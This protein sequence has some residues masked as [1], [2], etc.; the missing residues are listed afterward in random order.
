MIESKATRNSNIEFLRLVAMFFIVAGHYL[1]YSGLIETVT[2][3]NQVFA[4]LIGS[5]ARIA[6]SLFLMIGIWYMIDREF[7]AR[8]L[9]K[10]YFEIWFYGVAITIGAAIMGVPVSKYGI[11]RVI[12]PF[13]LN[14]VWFGTAYISLLMASPFLRKMFEWDRWV[15][16]NFII[17]LSIIIVPKTSI[18]GFND[19]WLDVMLWF[20][21]MY[22]L[23]G[24]YKKY[25]YNTIKA[26]GYLLAI[27]GGICIS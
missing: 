4:Y 19:T 18:S 5:G 8:R 13:T 26:K 3:V 14:S 7:S 23:V 6:V 11:L 17:V 22:L 20:I 24:Y 10:L 16:R 21:Y 9:L 25:L 2:G 15:I 27:G 12:F 1:S